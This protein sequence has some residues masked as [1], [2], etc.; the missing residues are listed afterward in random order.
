[1]RLDQSPQKRLINVA[2][3]DRPAAR[4]ALLPL[5]AEGTFNDA[6]DGLVE[7]RIGID[8]DRVLA[9][10]LRNYPFDID[11]VLR[12][13]GG[14]GIDRQTDGSRTRKGDECHIGMLDEAGPG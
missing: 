9:S 11:A 5:I 4:R 12:N 3:Y 10:H 8:D 6:A 14:L 2:D 13:L 1:R 7:V